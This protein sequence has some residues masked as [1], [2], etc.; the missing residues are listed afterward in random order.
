[1]C[2]F[3]SKFLLGSKLADHMK[4][5]FSLKIVTLRLELVVVSMNYKQ[6]FIV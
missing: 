4:L 1:M 6:F 5:S 3:S 2:S